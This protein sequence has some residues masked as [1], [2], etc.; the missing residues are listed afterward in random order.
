MLNQNLQFSKQLILGGY[1]AVIL[2]YRIAMIK[3]SNSRI[4]NV[5]SLVVNVVVVVIVNIAFERR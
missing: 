2:P 3:L 5:L 1:R 4:F